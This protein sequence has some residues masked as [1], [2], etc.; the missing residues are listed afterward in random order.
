MISWEQLYGYGAY[1]CDPYG[2]QLGKGVGPLVGFVCL[3]VQANA[4]LKVSITIDHFGGQTLTGLVILL[5]TCSSL[6]LFLQC[7]LGWY[8]ISS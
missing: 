7:C 4:I 6:S 2:M 5:Q 8:L 3:L 1:G